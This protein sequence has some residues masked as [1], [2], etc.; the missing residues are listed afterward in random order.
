MFVILFVVV[1]VFDGFVVAE[2]EEER[3]EL[4]KTRILAG[5][6]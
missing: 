6:V 2:K 1:V 4:R 3:T 5:M